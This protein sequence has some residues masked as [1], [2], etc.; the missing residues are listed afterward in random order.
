MPA[1]SHD[2][3]MLMFS[4]C[5][6]HHDNYLCLAYEHGNILEVNCNNKPHENNISPVGI[7]EV[8]RASIY[9]SLWINNTWKM[10]F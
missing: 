10:P 3:N 5:N 9:F 8:F 7:L 6:V 4:K 2:T 1:Y